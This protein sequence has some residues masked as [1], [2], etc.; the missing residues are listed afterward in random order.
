MAENQKHQALLRFVRKAVDVPAGY[1]KEDMRAFRAQA[2]REYPS[3]VPVIDA[4]IKLAQASDTRVA[5]P[6]SGTRVRRRPASPGEMHLFDLL[7]E[8]QLFPQNADLAEFAA[9]VLPNFSVRRLDKM[10]RGDIATRIIEHLEARDD[11]TRRELE[12]SMREAMAVRPGTETE[13]E[14]FL[15]K[16]EKIIKGIEL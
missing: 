16:W 12:A 9:R 8:K 1:T 14:S 13:R 10:R 11:K 6:D 15:S 2:V 3:L 5:A 7:R 4:Y